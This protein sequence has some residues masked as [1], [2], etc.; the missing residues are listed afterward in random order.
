MEG[1]VCGCWHRPRPRPRRYRQ[2]N[3]SPAT[4]AGGGETARR[5]LGRHLKNACRAAPSA[6]RPDLRIALASRDDVSSRGADDE[7]GVA[8][9]GDHPQRRRLRARMG[10]LG[11][12]RVQ[13]RARSRARR[14][15]LFATR[16]RPCWDRDRDS[17]SKPPASA[18]RLSRPQVARGWGAS[19]R[20]PCWHSW[21]GAGD[22]HGDGGDGLAASPPVRSDEGAGL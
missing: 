19:P 3:S 5:R 8:A 22:R 1:G 13:H 9:G 17:R 14:P 11:P 12:Q 6:Y 18:N 16:F 21:R 2:A 4:R 20:S 10:K 7:P 15:R